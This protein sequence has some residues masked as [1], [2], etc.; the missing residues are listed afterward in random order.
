MP[1]N[2]GNLGTVENV[3]S[4]ATSQP[5]LGAVEN[6]ASAATSQPRGYVTIHS[7]VRSE[8]NTEVTVDFL[9]TIGEQT[10]A[11]QLRFFKDGTFRQ[12]VGDELVTMDRW[13]T[14]GV[15]VPIPHKGGMVADRH[16]G[17]KNRDVKRPFYDRTGK[18]GEKVIKVGGAWDTVATTLLTT[19]LANFLKGFIDP[20]DAPGAGAGKSNS[21]QAY[22]AIR[23]SAE[24]AMRAELDGK[25]AAFEAMIASNPAM[26]AMAVDIKAGMGLTPGAIAAS[27][28][29]A[30]DAAVAARREAVSESKAVTSGAIDPDTLE[31]RKAS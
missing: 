15:L 21:V 12:R 24:A 26:A 20:D 22:I 29:A 30:G 31:T 28:K 6:V 14:E 2:S 10:E 3:A 1:R 13:D 19:G 17:I 16:Y 23:Q 27:V 11:R 4:T 9:F 8:D 7:P 25:L 18:E 5:D